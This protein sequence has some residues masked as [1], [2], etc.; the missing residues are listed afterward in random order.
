MSETDK[1][2]RILH[3]SDIHLGTSDQAKNYFTQLVTDLTQNLKVKQLNYLVLS[4]D[5]A[6][7][8]TVEE[9]DAAFELVDKLVNRY[10]LDPNRVITVPGNHDL[11][12]DLSEEA[13]DFVPK[14]KLPKSLKEGQ[15]IDAGD[16][17]ALI[18]D[19]DRYQQRFKHFSDRFYKKV[20][21]QPYPLEYDKQAILH[22]C[23]DDK[24]LF[25]A[26][27]SCWELDHHYKDRAS[28]KSEAISHA[29][30][31]ILTGNYDDWLK[32]AVWHHPVTSAESMK[33][34]AFLEQLA[35]LKFQVA[36]HG[37]IHQAKDENFQ[38]DT[39][40]GLRIIA[41]GTFGAPAKEQVTSIPLQ[42]N[43]LVLNPDNG[44]LT[45]ETRKKEKVDG[46]WSADARWGDKENPVKNYTIPLNYGQV[47]KKPDNISSQPNN[48]STENLPDK[49][50]NSLQSILSNVKVGGNFTVGNITQISN[51][52]TVPQPILT[53]QNPPPQRTILVLAASPTDMPGLRLDKEIRE[54][55]EGLRLAK[56]RDNFKLEQ[57]LAARTEDLRR[58]LLQYE[59]QI[60][61]FC[62]HGETDGIFLENDAGTKQLVPKEA[63]TNLFKLFSKR[64]V[65]C[66]VL[67][68]C[69]SDE[70]AEEIS[71]HINFVV[72]MSRAVG[73]KAAIQFAVG[74]YDGLG[75]GWTYEDAYEL[76]CNAIALEGI[77]EELTPVLKKKAQLTET[78]SVE[79]LVQQVRQKN[80]D[81][82]QRLHGT[83][84]LL[85]VANPVE[86]DR[87]YVDVNVLS[88]P[89][90]YK[91]LEIDDFRQNSSQKTVSGIKAV[92]DY[93]KLVLLG[94]PGAGKSTFL[95][96]VVIECNNGN[97][98]SDRVPVFIKLR[99]YVRKARID[100]NFNLKHHI[101]SYLKDIS[102]QEF[103][104]ILNEGKVLLLLDG[105]DE[106][107]EIDVDRVIDFI[108]YLI[109]NYPFIRIIITCRI[110][111][112][113]YQFN[114]FTSVQI[115]D[116]LEPQIVAFAENW[117]AASYNNDLEKGKAKAEKF[118]SQL[119]LSEN[120]Q[121]LELATM[122][123]L[124]SLICK[125]FSAKHQFYSKRHK[126]YEQG[127]KILLSKWDESRRIK[128]DRLYQDLNL[129]EKV[130][131]LSYIAARKFEQEQYV[132]FE[133]SEIQRYISEYLDILEEDSQAVLESII[134]Q[135]GLLIP[136]AQLIYS[137][138]HLTFQ[139]FFA[140]KW[141]IDRSQWQDL[142]NFITNKSCREVFLL[143]I[144]IV[145][146]ADELLQQ[147]KIQIDNLLASDEKL[148]QFLAWI[149]RKSLLVDIDYKPA[150][151][152]AFYLKTNHCSGLDLG[153]DLAFA[154]DMNLKNHSSG[155]I[156]Q[157][158]N[159][160]IHIQ[161][162]SPPHSELYMDEQLDAI[163]SK[164]LDSYPNLTT[165]LSLGG[166]D[167]NDSEFNRAFKEIQSQLP[168]KDNWDEDG[169]IWVEQLQNLS[170]EY[171]MIGKN[172]QFSEE[173]K[174]LLMQYYDANKLLVDCLN[175]S[176]AVRDE[177]RKEI[178]NTLLLLIAEI[179]KRKQSNS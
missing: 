163:I 146:N 55:D 91:H 12:W 8:S 66:V 133:K 143:L 14:R 80:R 131:L 18:P 87:L 112:N 148:Q 64:G 124:L 158:I 84:Q 138:S 75:A 73:D 89:T 165:K 47:K 111:G 50:N 29:V 121:I 126:L 3:L 90:N 15:Y 37:H 105:L 72:G 109:E 54:I 34:V 177:V 141:F 59:P 110:Q 107:P 108:N 155:G 169:I 25:L 106:V 164:C 156:F 44:E 157:G 173:Q 119:K 93:Q 46:A 150:S 1:Q 167:S 82:I 41:A 77:P 36:M 129:E 115:A 152:R 16:A 49:P 63:L 78:N 94:K 162:P 128:R 114:G 159:A 117:F 116:F 118:M 32:I 45:V 139:E 154:I 71:E 17:G 98:L 33:N 79:T 70:Q 51:S 160:D 38:Y 26:L 57:R 9:Y 60:V 122:P 171:R 76:G 24:I 7:Y 99:D 125:I 74:F 120:K 166:I 2:I 142:V 4:G 10:G 62:G 39:N 136:R 35:T 48:A 170:I 149:A 144:E 153:S 67:N 68:A 100:E 19:Q 172:W 53:S 52:G 176:C 104:V 103:E 21:S 174:E 61:H 42:Y 28:I 6:N 85:D 30:D 27:N 113:K 88:E 178:E 147:M 102:L 96:H 101:Y 127:L 22:S 168:E 81:R 134:Q 20:Y 5:I 31:Q 23:P 97:L 161:F 86:I 69:Y 151:I 92:E 130:K 135:H 83:I 132:L 175:S 179:E 40:R 56:K 137:F 11:N 145:N 95:Q 140:A 123:L 65:Q 13:Y 43:L 58:A